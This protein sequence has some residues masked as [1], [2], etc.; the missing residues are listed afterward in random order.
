M[1]STE[2]NPG[3]VGGLLQLRT[4]SL[5]RASVVDMSFLSELVL[6][7][8][9]NLESAGGSDISIMAG[10]T[11]LTSLNLNYHNISDLTP[12]SNLTMLKKLKLNN[13][14]IAQLAPLANMTDVSGLLAVESFGH[15]DLFG[16]VNI[17]CENKDALAEKFGTSVRLPDE[18]T[19]M[20]EGTRQWSYDVNAHQSIRSTPAISADGTIYISGYG[21]YLNAVNPNGTKKWVHKGEGYGY[22]SVSVR[23]D[24]TLLVSGHDKLYALN[25]SA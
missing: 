3:V 17:S 21:G 16:N 8:S 15:L 6:L 14:N 12:I 9:L 7:E 2:F 19:Q 24:G 11:H 4:L 20:V 1:F 5:E 25:K 10:L 22:G 13:N 23:A 18:C